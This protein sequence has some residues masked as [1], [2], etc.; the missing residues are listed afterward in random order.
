MSQLARGLRLVEDGLL[1]ALLSTLIVLAAYQVIARNYFDTGLIWGDAFVRVC[2]LWITMVGAML[3][4]RSDEHIS[5][6]LV[7]RFASGERARWARR[8]AYLFTC[9]LCGA[10]AY[11]SAEFVRSEYQYETIALASVLA[12][13]CAAVMRVAAAVT[14]IRYL[15]HT[16]SPP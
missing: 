9:L 11:Y 14:A 1:V 6:D 16:I 8:C 12:W 3:A 10:F 5:I 2:V 13:A 4:S 7:S 15:L